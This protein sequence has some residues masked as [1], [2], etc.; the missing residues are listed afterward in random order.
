MQVSLSEIDS[1][2]KVSFQ[3]METLAERIV[4]VREINNLT[5]DEFALALGVTRG[6]VGNWEL[7]GGVSR[8]NLVRIR[9]RFG[10]SLD[11]LQGAGGAAP[12]RAG[13]AEPHKLDATSEPHNAQPAPTPNLNSVVPLVG[14][15]AAGPDGS[16]PFNGEKVADVP[17]SPRIAGVSGA[18]ALY[19][20][21]SS[22]EERYFN[23]EIVF[24][25]PHRRYNRGNFVVVQVRGKEGDTPLG[26][27]K[28][29]VSLDDRHL[30]LEQLNPRKVLTFPRSKVVSIHRIIMGGEE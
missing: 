21:G 23:G 2:R 18:Y 24:V 27:I 26:Y 15:G 6:A 16:F 20:V 19:V 10:A 3:S 29:F 14:Q 8:G 4:Y 28:K 5:Q 11:W 30:K 13:V 22:M 9:D 7:G 17:A 1:A 25:D 12:E